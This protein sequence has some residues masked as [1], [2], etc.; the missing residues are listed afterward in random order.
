ML[1]FKNFKYPH[2]GLDFPTPSWLMKH[3]RAY[4]PMEHTA[5]R[6][7]LLFGHY[8]SN[9]TFKSKWELASSHHSLWSPCQ[10][11]I[12]HQFHA[13][14]FLVVEL[15]MAEYLLSIF[16]LKGRKC[17]INRRNMCFI[18]MELDTYFCRDENNSYKNAY[19]NDV[20]CNNTTGMIYLAC[21]S[22]S[23]YP[24]GSAGISSFSRNNKR[25][26]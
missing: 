16:Q 1:I 2:K 7:M 4:V 10:A 8:L 3:C 6:W 21:L 12:Y 14:V 22:H 26:P 23:Q 18:K 5:G 9:F 25:V 24:A 20:W 13:I 17:R 19:T 15:K 11:T